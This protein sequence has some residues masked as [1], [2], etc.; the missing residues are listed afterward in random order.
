MASLPL[1]M[2]RRLSVVDN[3]GDGTTGGHN[4]DE[5]NVDDDGATG[6]DDNNDQDGATEDKVNYDDGNCAM[7]DDIDG[8]CD[9]ATMM[10]KTRHQRRR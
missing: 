3:D 7:D 5:D 8:D 10:T 1:P 2:L 4:D 9:G 6:D